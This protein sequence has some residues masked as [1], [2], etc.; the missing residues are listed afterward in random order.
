MTSEKYWFK[1]SFNEQMCDIYGEV[2]QVICYWEQIRERKSA[3]KLQACYEFRLAIALLE[4]TKEDPKNGGVL[5]ELNFAE[6]E[7]KSFVEQV[8]KNKFIAIKTDVAAKKLN[9]YWLKYTYAYA[10]ELKQK[11]EKTRGKLENLKTRKELIDSIIYATNEKPQEVFDMVLCSE[12]AD[13]I[14]KSLQSE[15]QMTNSQ[16]QAIVDI[17]LKSFAK[18]EIAQLKE[19]QKKLEEMSYYK[20]LIGDKEI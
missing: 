10:A 19:E 18:A 8:D 15:F 6:N 9:D 11:E 16:V 17:R 7:L 5:R 20:S 4:M 14:K 3:I 12:T 13:D 1:K 2:E